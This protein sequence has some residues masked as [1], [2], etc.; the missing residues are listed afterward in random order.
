[1][2]RKGFGYRE[3]KNYGMDLINGGK[4]RAT[5]KEEAFIISPNLDNDYVVYL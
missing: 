1:M 2:A 5:K 3:K 4:K